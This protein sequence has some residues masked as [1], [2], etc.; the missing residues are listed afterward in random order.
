MAVRFAP[1]ALGLSAAILLCLAAVS[2]AA[3]SSKLAARGANCRVA[4]TIKL[5]TL[6][7]RT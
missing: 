2:D 1:E 5:F 4:K 6:S 3:D 7:G